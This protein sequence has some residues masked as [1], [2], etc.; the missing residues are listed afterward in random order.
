MKQSDIFAPTTTSLL[1]NSASNLCT[2]TDILENF[3]KDRNKIRI[4]NFET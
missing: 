4:S 3:V 1:Y 2:T